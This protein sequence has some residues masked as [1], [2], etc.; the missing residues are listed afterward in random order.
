MSL[1]VLCFD[2]LSDHAALVRLVNASRSTGV[3]VVLFQVCQYDVPLF[4][5]YWVYIRG[6]LAEI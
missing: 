4:G 3:H 1:L 2:L 6:S 5:L